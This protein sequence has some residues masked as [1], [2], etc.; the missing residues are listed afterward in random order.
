MADPATVGNATSYQ[1][2]SKGASMYLYVIG[3]QGRKEYQYHCVMAKIGIAQNAEKRLSSMQTGSPDV[4]SFIM[5]F[6]CE[7]AREIEQQIHTIIKGIDTHNLQPVKL[8]IRGEW[9]FVN[10]NICHLILD[11]MAYF[12]KSPTCLI[13][14]RCIW[15]PMF[16]H[17]KLDTL[18][19][20]LKAYEGIER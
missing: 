9:F 5:L 8:C 12:G 19:D 13:D 14:N 11:V 1:H 15:W 20:G 10:L 16:S 2:L 18:D 3:A 4:L 17:L 6:E 7:N